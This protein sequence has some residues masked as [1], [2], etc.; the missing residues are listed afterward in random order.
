M[1]KFD[2]I[3]TG[4]L[5]LHG[6]GFLQLQ[7]AGNRR[8]HVWHPDLPKRRCFEFSKVHNHRFS[9]TAEVLI[10]TQWNVRCLVESDPNGE[11]TKYYH[12][13]PRNEH[14][15]R[16]WIPDGTVTITPGIVESIPAGSSY[17]SEMFEYHFTAVTGNP[18]VTLLTKR[19]EDKSRGAH[20]TCHN[21]AEPDVD[22]N[23]SQLPQSRLWEIFQDALKYG[24]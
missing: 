24:N 13:G 19:E 7:L 20:S 2:R 3:D 1:E 11:W 10:G 14:G 12:E 21:C 16:P 22:F 4:R 6:L 17:T 9:F 15:S 23:G 5:R 8:L 18:V